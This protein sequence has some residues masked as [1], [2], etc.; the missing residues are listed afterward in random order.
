MYLSYFVI[1]CKLYLPM[2][3]LFSNNEISQ[4]ICFFKVIANSYCGWKFSS[5]H[6]GL[7]WL[8]DW[9]LCFRYL[10]KCVCLRGP[11]IQKWQK[12]E[13]STFPIVY[14]FILEK[15]NYELKHIFEVENQNV[16]N[17]FSNLPFEKQR[18][19]KKITHDN[20]VSVLHW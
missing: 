18:D 2:V 11:Q 20:L 17:I 10:T 14:R 15:Y 4:I 5:F 16:L 1:I 12:V 3:D 19:C 9:V 7:L 13:M 6:S 8:W